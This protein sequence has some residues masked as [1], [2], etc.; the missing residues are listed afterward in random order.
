MALV[1]PIADFVVSLGADGR[2]HSQGSLSRVLE[3][4]KDLASVFTEQPPDEKPER[5]ANIPPLDTTKPVKGKLV[6][7][8]EVSVGQVSWRACG[9]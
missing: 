5:S 2:V 1:Q 9:C 4:D 3:A 7:D 8:E 6:V